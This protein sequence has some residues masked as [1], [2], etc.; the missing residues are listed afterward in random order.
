MDL[1]ERSLQMD[2]VAHDFFIY[3]DAEDR[4]YNKCG[5]YRREAWRHRSIGVKE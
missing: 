2:P 4:K 1:D 3:R 5:I